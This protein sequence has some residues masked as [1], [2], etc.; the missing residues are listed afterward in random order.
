[1]TNPE[2]LLTKR[3][4]AAI[5]QVHTRTVERLVARG[6]LPAP[7]RVGTYAVR[8]RA[9]DVRA[10]LAALQPATRAA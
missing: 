3:Q 2:I 10:W 5:A 1:M 9:S 7:V 8:W 6:A 4:V